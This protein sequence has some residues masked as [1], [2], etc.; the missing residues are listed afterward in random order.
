MLQITTT[1]SKFQFPFGLSH[2][3]TQLSKYGQSWRLNME[4]R[5]RSYMTAGRPRNGTLAEISKPYGPVDYG[6]MQVKTYNWGIN[7]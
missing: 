6:I 4:K 2:N 5:T 3:I 7:S 1:L